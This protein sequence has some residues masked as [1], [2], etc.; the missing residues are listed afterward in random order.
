MSNL[1]VSTKGQSV[2]GSM[3]D[4]NGFYS[5]ILNTALRDINTYEIAESYLE[6]LKQD[7]NIDPFADIGMGFK[8]LGKPLKD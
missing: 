8:N 5:D 1:N 3:S 7:E 6:D 4:K 2:H